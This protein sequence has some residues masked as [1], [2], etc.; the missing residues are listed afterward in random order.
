MPATTSTAVVITSEEFL[1]NQEAY[2]ERVDAGEEV[3]LRRGESKLYELR[4]REIDEPIDED[5][6]E[7]YTSEV[8]AEIKL[9]I[10]EAKAGKVTRIRDAAHRKELLG[11]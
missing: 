10:A 4:P 9:S 3:L 5:D 11:L 8:V 2:F 1:Q 6:M 7:Y